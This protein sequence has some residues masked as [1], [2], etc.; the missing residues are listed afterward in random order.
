[1]ILSTKLQLTTVTIVRT[2][3]V[4]ALNR[5]SGSHEPAQAADRMLNDFAA[6][7]GNLPTIDIQT[8]LI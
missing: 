8:T 2:F 6:R 7:A 4:S 1:M 5:V 3:S